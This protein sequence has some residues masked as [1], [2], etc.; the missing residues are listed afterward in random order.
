MIYTNRSSVTK[1][2]HGVTFGPGETKEVSGIIN[3]SMFVPST[4]KEPPK[5]V[6]RTR[7]EPEV[8]ASPEVI[9]SPRKRG[10]RKAVEITSA[11]VDT[12][13]DIATSSDSTES[14]NAV[15]KEV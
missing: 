2:F 3:D 12:D 15:N 8:V 14:E 9:E 6:R 10:R 11:E 13:K 1:T 7:S 5:R 4:C